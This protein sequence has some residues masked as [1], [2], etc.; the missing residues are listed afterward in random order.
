M[1]IGTLHMFRQGISSI[2]DQQSRLLKTQNQ[3]AVGKRIVNPSDDPTG[4]A[5]LIGLSETSKTTA[6]FQR[7]ILAVRTRLEL[8]D[9]VLGSVG[10]ALQ[11]VR[12]LTVSALN[13]TNGAGERI[14]IAAEV[15]QLAN[16]AMGLA[17]HKDGNGQYMFAGFQV[18]TVPFSETAP[19]VFSYAGDQGQR[20]IQI[21]PARQLADGDSGQAVFMD[22][23]DGSG[24]FED[25]FT[26]LEN[27]ATDLEANAPNDSSLDQLDRTMDHLL[28]AR[29]SAGARLNALESQE[30]IN[31]ALLVQLEQ[32]RSTIEDLD[33]AEA[34]TRLSQE[35]V[36]L[37]AAQQSF[38][39][40]QNLNLF[41][42]L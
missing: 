6:Q 12:E 18:L 5:Q 35:S 17:N 21:G 33:Y 20:Q 27:L 16:N 31:G 28:R 25:I 14:A 15:R 3:L 13:D 24:G 7:N 10:D 39:K 29:A 22:I 36:I 34:A 23:A 11:R 40:V 26:T 32:T 8:Q 41:N 1:R 9:G 19:G 2:L 38:V 4:S 37:Q 30:N 42:F